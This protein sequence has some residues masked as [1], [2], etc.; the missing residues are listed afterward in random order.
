MIKSKRKNG[1]N[2]AGGAF[3]GKTSLQIAE[4]LAA[5][6]NDLPS[7]ESQEVALDNI[8]A[9]VGRPE[10]KMIPRDMLIPAPEEWNFFPKAS[11]DKIMEMSES[12]KQY[13]LLHNITVWAQDDGSYMIL[14][15]HTRV[16][17]YE[18]LATTDDNPN[19]W[20]KIPALVYGKNQL[21][22]TDAKRI[23][24]VSN[25]DQRDLSAAMK[26]KSYMAL[27]KLEKQKAF[28]GNYF[29]SRESAASQANVSQTVF[30]RYLCLSKLIPELQ[31]E[32]EGS[33]LFM[34]G[35]HLSYLP[36]QLQKYLYTSGAYR[37]ITSQA[38]AQLKKCT[39][40]EE[41]KK[42][43]YDIN[44]AS[45]YYKYTVQTR[46]QKTV[47]EEVL[48]LFIKKDSRNEI[49]DLYIQAVDKMDYP[50]NVKKKL[51]KIMSNAKR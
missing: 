28:Y 16:A 44:H 32:I 45:K 49:A 10:E 4:R 17:C 47:D 27:L 30:Y 2:S 8:D 41:L 24:I 23:V 39:T 38:A 13:G 22:E 25:T 51:I 42:K 35:F 21:S 36:K 6:K 7:M 19:K 18:Y 37:T 29:N 5:L 1:N 31:Q 12:I 20:A 26:S 15:G 3:P 46:I 40:L 50:P 14:G 33:L 11:I 9:V 34:A 43:L 48:P